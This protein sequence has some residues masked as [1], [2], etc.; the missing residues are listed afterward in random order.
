MTSPMTRAAEVGD[1]PRDHHG[2]A[3]ALTM[4][5]PTKWWGKPFLRVLFAGARRLGF[6]TEPLRMNQFIH[7]A[8]WTLLDEL[9]AADGRRRLRRPMLWFES[10]FDGNLPRYMDTFARALTWRMRA[11][12][13]PTSGFPGL[14]PLSRFHRWTFRNAVPAGHYWSAYPDATTRDVGRA[15]TVDARFAEL[16]DELGDDFD[17][18]R[19]ERAWKRFLTDVQV[20]L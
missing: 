13:G 12:W 18:D 6:V 20:V 5:L 16:L 4:Y 11:A 17:I 2:Q 7:F 8:R 14:F 10:N 1:D 9:P 19:F 15:L 3:T